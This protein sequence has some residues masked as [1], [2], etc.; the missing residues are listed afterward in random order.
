M[1][2]G[3]GGFGVGLGFAGLGVGLGLEESLGFGEPDFESA[4]ALGTPRLS[5]IP[6]SSVTQTFVIGFEIASRFFISSM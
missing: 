1:G 6:T 2:V 3:F 5:P 4:R